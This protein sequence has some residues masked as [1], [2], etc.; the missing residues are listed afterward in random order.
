MTIP[1]LL[2]WLGNK[3]VRP[4]SLRLP[5]PTM[6]LADKEIGGTLIPPKIL[7]VFLGFLEPSTKTASK[8]CLGH[9]HFTWTH[10]EIFEGGLS[11]SLSLSPTEP[12][13][14]HTLLMSSMNAHMETNFILS[15]NLSAFDFIQKK[16]PISTASWLT[17]SSQ[18][19]LTFLS[20]LR[21]TV[22]FP[23]TYNPTKALI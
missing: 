4:K 23:Y 13:V 6:V 15:L 14:S 3:Y 20:P 19:T 9:Y 1:T 10:R 12:Q 11:L 7:K 18:S 8:G 5:V 22:F 16:F 17:E 2:P 21:S